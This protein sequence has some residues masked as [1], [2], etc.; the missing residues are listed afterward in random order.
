MTTIAAALADLDAAQKLNAD[1]RAER[2]NALHLLAKTSEAHAAL[3]V[4]HQQLF[5]AL[6]DARRQIDRLTEQC[7]LLDES[8]ADLLRRVDS[9]AA[10]RDT[11]RAKAE[12]R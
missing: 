10:E 11:W 1:L 9:V 3:A 8:A 4:E 5:A 2:D 6:E 7:G 12:I